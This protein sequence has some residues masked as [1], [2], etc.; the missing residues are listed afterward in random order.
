MLLLSTKCSVLRSIPSFL[1][2]SCF[3]GYL[4]I[5]HK[6]DFS[7]FRS[8]FFF[9]AWRKN[10]DPFGFST[11]LHFLHIVLKV[12]HFLFYCFLKRHAFSLCY[13]SSLHFTSTTGTHQCWKL[14]LCLH[15]RVLGADLGNYCKAVI[16]EIR[17]I[18]RDTLSG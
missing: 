11:G 2:L 4:L 8:I 9:R 5:Q 3:Y 12:V 17:F 18:Y 6:A 10:S 1:H 15:M 16:T 14:I 7:D 13:G